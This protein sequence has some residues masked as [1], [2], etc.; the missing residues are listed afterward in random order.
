[1]RKT[2]FLCTVFIF[3]IIGLESIQAQSSFQF[4]DAQDSSFIPYVKVQK[5]GS[6]RLHYSDEKGKASLKVKD[7]DTLVFSCMGYQSYLLPWSPNEPEHIY[8]KA[9]QKMLGAVTVKPRSEKEVDWE[10]RHADIN[11]WS[12][13]G[14]EMAYLIDPGSTEFPLQLNQLKIKLRNG[15]NVVRLS[16]YTRQDS[17]PGQMLAIEP[18]LITAYSG[19]YLELNLEARQLKFEEPFFMVVEFI[20]QNSE[21]KAMGGIRYYLRGS[22]HQRTWYKYPKMESWRS[23]GSGHG[24]GSLVEEPHLN[25][26]V[27][28]RYR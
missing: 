17:M 13:S 20:H 4:F 10:G 22:E 11:L 28:Y 21:Y 25:M 27:K 5:R 12:N 1:M 15:D 19:P 8:L 14:M 23:L 9:D 26:I 7:G 6:A 16:F 3:T 2:G 18:I 24:L